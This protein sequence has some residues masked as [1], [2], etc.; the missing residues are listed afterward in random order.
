MKDKISFSERILQGHWPHWVGAII[1]AVLNILLT[2]IYK[3]WSIT[4]DMADWGI[5]MWS[6]L[7]GHPERWQ[8]YFHEVGYESLFKDPI[9][10][11][12]TILNVGLM[13]GVLLSVA[14]AAEFRIKR[15]KS[16][17]QILMGII[18]GLL[19]GYGARLALGCNVGAMVGGIASQSL[20]GWVFALFLFFGSLAGSI[21]VRRCFTKTK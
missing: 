12:Q 4:G 2:A 14:L 11:E 18:G 13:A 8:S 15:I 6:S 5:Q 16:G 1:L 21:L 19:M 9:F 10:N 3:P 20:H 7:R 17:R